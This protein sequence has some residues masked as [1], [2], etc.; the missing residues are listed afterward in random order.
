MRAVIGNSLLSQVKPK[1]TH[2]DIRDE[3]LI[4]FILRVHPTGKMVYRCEY[5]RG[6]KITIGTTK[7]LTP[8]Q[9]RDR[10][11]EILGQVALGLSPNVKTCDQLT[12]LDFVK[13]EYIPWRL[14]NRKNIKSDLKRLEVNFIKKF[15]NYIL[16]EIS[17]ILID[18]W[19]TNRINNG[20]RI[21]T[22]NRD[23]VILKATLSKAVE[24]D[25][26]SEH[27]LRQIKAESTF[28]EGSVFT[29]ELPYRVD[30]EV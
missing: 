27:P 13:R 18:K 11:K 24:W 4:G 2:Y 10:V 16:S 29:I 6:K 22:V 25:F 15:G 14:A 3:K 26:I 23:I 21:A 19:R 12:L 7:V 28:G 5:G 17:P 20:I 8:Q 9:A 30:Q 1:V